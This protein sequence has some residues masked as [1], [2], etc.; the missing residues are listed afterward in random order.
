MKRVLTIAD[1]HSGHA[2]G[3]THPDF[4]ITHQNND[5]DTAHKQAKSRRIHWNWFASQVDA[6]KPIDILFV[7]ADCID[8]RGE[9]SGGTELLATD[10]NVQ[11]QMATAAIDYCEASKVYLTYGTPYHTGGKEDWERNVYNAIKNAEA[12][13]SHLFVDVEGLIFDIKHKVGSS[14]IPHGRHTAVAKERLWNVLWSEH[15]E[16]PKSDVIIRSHVHYHTFCGGVDW[17]AMT[18]PALQTLGSKYGTRQCSGVVD[19]G[20]IHFDV[21]GKDNYK[22]EAHILKRKTARAEVL[23]A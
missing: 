8:G 2:I 3:L 10:R 20:F 22:W 23:K 15:G 9:K 4:D 18:T 11:V 12:I 17:L 6:L 16:Y 5:N 1:L 14:S 13:S 21:E 19:F 7:N